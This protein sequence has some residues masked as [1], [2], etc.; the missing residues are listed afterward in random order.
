MYAPALVELGDELGEHIATFTQEVLE[1]ETEPA[2]SSNA[3]RYLAEE[4]TA[5]RPRFVLA[6][7]AD[8]LVDDFQRGLDDLGARINTIFIR[9]GI[10]NRF[11]TMFYTELEHHSGQLRY[12]NAG[13]NPALPTFR[14]SSSPF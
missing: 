5:E 10:D 2:V 6:A 7:D 12:L 14:V 11:A 9:D 13:H 4:L 8:K 1:R 3:G